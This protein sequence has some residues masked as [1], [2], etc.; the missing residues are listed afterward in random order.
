MLLRLITLPY[1]RK[2]RLRTALTL[3]GIALGVAVF[4]GM[5]TSNGTVLKAFQ[6]TVNRIAGSTELQVSAGEAG[7]DEEVLERV[8]GVEGVRVAVPVVEAAVATGIEG[9]GNLL[10]LG[11]DMTGDRSLRD[12]EFDSGEEAVIDDP[13][14]FL[15]QPDSLMVTREFAERNHLVTGSKLPLY[16][17][18]GE[19][20]FTIRGIM[21][22]GG[23]TSAFGGNLAIMDVYAAQKVF[24][25]GRK[26]DRI[27]LATQPDTSLDHLR[28]RLERMLGPAFQVERPGSRGRQF[29]SL[30]R[31][32]SAV[33]N[34]ASL[35]AL[36]I[37][38]FIIYN[39]FAIAV[40]QRRS[41]IGV[42]RALG[43][44]RAQ[45]RGLFLIESA[46]LGLAGS[47]IG[48]AFGILLARGSSSYISGFLEQV[49]GV[50]QKVED[51]A[52]DPAL[53][54]GAVA[55]GVAASMVAA[56]LPARNAARVDPVQALQKGKYQVLAAGENRRRRLTAALAALAAVVCFIFDQSRLLFYSGY[57]LSIAA[58]LLL[59]PSLAMCLARALRPALKWFRP[60]EGALAA[61]SLLQAPRR[62]SATVAAL[63]LSLAL[64][65]GLGGIA[66]ANFD[67]IEQWVRTTLN[68]DLYVA[69]SDN[70][71]TRSFRFPASMAHELES[72]EGIEQ[73][74]CVRSVR[75]QYRGRPI[76]VTAVEIERLASKV[77][78]KPVAGD[79]R[80]MNRLA[81]LGQG[82]IISANLSEMA[83]LRLGD[84][85]EIPAPQGT[86]RLP[87]VGVLTDYSDQGGSVLIDRRVFIKYWNDDS[88]NIF[89]VYVKPGVSVV[90]ARS[91]I[92]NRLG[93]QRRLFVLTNEDVRRFILGIT[94]Q[95]FGL[96]YMQI[97]VAVLV[98]ILG[99][100]NTLTVSITDRRR[101][102]GVLQ[103]V[104]ALR[105]Q[106]RHTIWMEAL[107]VGFIGLVLGLSL[108]AVNLHY[109]IEIGRRDI[110][111][112][113]MAYQ[114][115]VKVALLLMPVILG[116]ALLA[117]LWPAESA[118]RGS[119]VEALEYE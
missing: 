50:P 36:F 95:W 111:G 59:T 71:T 45:I 47:V 57:V 15:A 23:L 73:V 22:S 55:L 82:A 43:A 86:L 24:G 83:K 87:V 60:V 38:V 49:Y 66:V 35:F 32:Y 100:V 20:V 65:V 13:L 17:I 102:L 78:R 63:M 56:F 18:D 27:D 114:Y 70:L 33:V 8:Q 85:M 53:M 79:E 11:V 3:V 44:T 42:L 10:I 25:R 81:A 93:R 107:S 117:S 28:E 89:R 12:Y 112:M 116:S 76:L 14:V 7:F 94:E 2:H 99:I 29:E 119:L 16:T 41:E 64:A 62:T 58:A 109:S 51:I 75:L 19:R 34:L 30:V 4:V 9:Q 46:V 54:L 39:A 115:P 69:T 68:P 110:A 105:R 61:D 80:E 37:G 92:L 77:R 48:L 26:F 84:V 101:E 1:V 72:I 74:Q 106:V 67:A 31:V 97:A 113:Q 103:A 118:V 52:L 21:R 5:H 98:A 104:G 6:K 40:T 90:D 108:G 91:R 96:S 88:V